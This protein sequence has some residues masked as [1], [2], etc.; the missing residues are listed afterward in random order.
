MEKNDAQISGF[1]VRK[2]APSLWKSFLFEKENVF[3]AYLCRSSID[4][5]SIDFVDSYFTNHVAKFLQDRIKSWKVGALR[6]CTGYQFFKRKSLV[7]AFQPSL[8]LSFEQK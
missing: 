7:R 4:K 3:P 5:K 6:V 1:A 8:T 2:K